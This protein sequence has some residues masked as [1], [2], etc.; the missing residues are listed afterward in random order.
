LQKHGWER[1][2]DDGGSGLRVPVWRRGG[3]IPKSGK[4]F[5]PDFVP[6]VCWGFPHKMNMIAKM[7]LQAAKTAARLRFAFLRFAIMQ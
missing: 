5:L 1:Y 3:G 2:G 7:Q 4:D 6:A